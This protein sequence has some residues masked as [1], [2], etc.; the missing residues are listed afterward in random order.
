MLLHKILFLD[1]QNCHAFQMSKQVRVPATNTL[2]VRVADLHKNS[3]WV[4]LNVT[5]VIVAGGK[6]CEEMSFDFPVKSK[7]KRYSVIFDCIFFDSGCS[8]SIP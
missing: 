6:A 3:H 7:I 8:V 1:K 2:H 4:R 5:N